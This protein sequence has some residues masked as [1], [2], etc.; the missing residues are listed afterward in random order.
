[1]NISTALRLIALAGSFK[2]VKRGAL[3]HVEYSFLMGVAI[4]SQVSIPHGG[5]LPRYFVEFPI[6]GEAGFGPTH[7]EVAYRNAMFTTLLSLFP[8]AHWGREVGY[9]TL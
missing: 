4:P 5:L 3:L 2:L 8:L 1:M 6:P 7:R 9:H